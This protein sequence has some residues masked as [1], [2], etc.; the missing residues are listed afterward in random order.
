MEEDEDPIGG[1]MGRTEAHVGGA[2]AQV[3]GAPMMFGE[4]AEGWG[5]ENEPRGAVGGV[6]AAGKNVVA[7]RRWGHWGGV[8]NS[9]QQHTSVST[10][11]QKLS[12]EINSTPIKYPSKP[13]I[14]HR[15]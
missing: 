10:L 1:Q 6:P 2:E 13:Q 5:D 12:G 3:G 9:C 4:E 11:I 15:D 14:K 8:L 7:F